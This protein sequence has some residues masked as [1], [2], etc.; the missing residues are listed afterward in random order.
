MPGILL[1]LLAVAAQPDVEAHTLAGEVVAGRLA[2]IRSEQVHLQTDQGPVSIAFDRLAAISPRQTRSTAAAEPPVRV[3]LVDGSAIAATEF[4]TEGE[5]AN[6]SLPDSTTMELRLD[7]VAAVRFQAETP[8]IAEHWSRLR[9]TAPATDLLVT[10]KAEA[11]DYHRGVVGDV[12]A[13]VVRFQ[14]DGE[15][16]PV[17]RSKLQGVIYYR[18]AVAEAPHSVCRITGADG[19]SWPAASVSLDGSDLSWK[20]PSGLEIRRPMDAIARIDFSQGKVVYLSD[21]EP[22]SAEWTP[23]LGTGRPL[24]SLVSF[25]GP[26]NDRSLLSGPLLLDGKSYQ[27]GLALHSRTVVTYRLPD[28][29]EHF[30]AIAGIDDRVRPRGSVRLIVRGDDRVLFDEMVDG[31]QTAVP[32]HVD[33]GDA[34]RLTIVVDFADDT[35]IADHLD[36]AEARVVK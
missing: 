12:D 17:K 20:T 26:R 9:S 23:Y 30:R 29:V 6:V 5:K 27:K 3:E 36:L 8:E 34:R 28:G 10:R 24:D 7:T 32:V 4:T 13:D 18:T 1:M 21:L 31:A 33:V 15:S 16:L 11:I 35:D 22:E 14:A 25:F 19:S 2:E